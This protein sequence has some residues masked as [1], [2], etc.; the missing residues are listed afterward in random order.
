ML[1]CEGKTT[2]Q[3]YKPRHYG[4]SLSYKCSAP[5][6]PSLVG[7]SYNFT[8]YGESNRT[9]C[10][11]FP[12]QITR[13]TKEC[14][15]FYNHMSLPNMIGNHDMNP[16]NIY[17]TVFELDEALDIILYISSQSPT[18][19]CHKYI[20]EVLCRIIF[21]QCDKAQNHVLHI[22]KETCSELL[23]SCLKQ[24]Q[25][26]LHS[27]HFSQIG[28][29]SKVKE[30]NLSAEMDCDYLP[31]VNDPITCYYKPVMCDPPPNVTNAR[32]IDG[33]VLSGTYLAA[34]QIEY[35]CLDESFQMEGKSTVTCL[36]SGKWYKISK[37]E[38]KNESNVN[39]LSIVIPLLIV[40]FCIFI[41]THIARRYVCRKKKLFL[42]KRNKEYDA[43]VCYNFDENHHFVF[44]SILPELEEKLDLPLKMFIHDRDFTP[45]REISINIYNAINSCNS[46]IIVMSQ[47]FVDSPRC[48]EEFTKC[49]AESE[50][51]PA[52]KLFVILMEE[53]NTLD[54]VPENMELFFREK[55]YLKSDDPKI[56]QKIENHLKLMRQHHAIDN[57]IELEHFCR[58]RMKHD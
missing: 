44:D 30:A 5:V 52:F 50:E 57:N 43:F 35:E 21:P 25:T 7:L 58:I 27:S 13:I 24:F 26:F 11:P 22:C 1:H 34:S 17:T 9:Q 39:A 36:Y 40:P 23:H 12:Q 16:Q 38:T 45:G 48:R 6:K 31:S 46:A 49:L 37:C 3:D 8:I 20:K 33:I 51:D 19:D 41:V 14:M 29:W 18:G 32:I 28:E 15:E 42:L 47:G 56:F 2:I 55:T 54:N 4:F 10:L 53:V